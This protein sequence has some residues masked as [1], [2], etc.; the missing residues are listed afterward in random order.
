MAQRSRHG[1][2]L[3]AEGSTVLRSRPAS[4]G[5]VAR[6]RRGPAALFSDPACGT[7]GVEIKDCSGVLLEREEGKTG[8]GKSTLLGSVQAVVGEVCS[9]EDIDQMGG[10]LATGET[11][12]RE[13]LQQA[14]EEFSAL[15]TGASMDLS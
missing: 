10:Q 2:R 7:G 4:S 14:R 1:R 5:D 12:L 6:S 11:V 13:R 9:D 3:F 8:A 15:R